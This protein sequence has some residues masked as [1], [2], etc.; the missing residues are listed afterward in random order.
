MKLH[1]DLPWGGSFDIEREKSD[2]EY[3]VWAL[4]IISAAAVLIAIFG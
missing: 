4:L 3:S 2:P 1:I